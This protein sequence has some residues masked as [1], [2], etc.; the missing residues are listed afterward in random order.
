MPNMLIHYGEVVDNADKTSMIDHEERVY[1]VL[2]E[3]LLYRGELGIG[4][5]GL[6]IGRHG[7]TDSDIDEVGSRTFYGTAD[8][9]IGDDA[10]DAVTLHDDTEAELAAAD[11]HERIGEEHGGRHDGEMVGVHDISHLDEE[12]A[13]ERACRMKLRK[14]LGLEVTRLHEGNGY[15]IAHGHGGCGAGR[16]GKIEGTGF[17]RHT[18]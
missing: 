11:G 2:A 1:L 12:L 3:H 18:A 16:G 7:L 14:V 10:E 13:S 15:G 5:D 17:A 8:V 6:G 4:T 9:A